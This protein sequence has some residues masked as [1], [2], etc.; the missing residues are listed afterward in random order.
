[1]MRKIV[2]NSSGHPLKNQKFFQSNEFLSDA[3]SEGKLIVRP[4]PA[5]VGNESL[6]FLKRLHGD[7]CCPIHPLY[8]PFR[9]FMVMIDASSGWSHVSML[10]TRNSAF[11]KFVSQIIR[12][13]A[14]FPD[15][16]IKKVRLDNVGEFFSQAFN[17]YC[18]SIGIDV[19]HLVCHVHTQNDMTESLIERL[20]LIA[21]PLILRTKLPISVWGHAILHVAVLVQIRPSAYNKYSLLRLTTGQEPN[22]GYLCVFGCAVYVPIALLQRKNIGPSPHKYKKSDKIIY[23]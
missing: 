9:Y 6:L 2:Q 21:R 13:K 11:A 22:V 20:Q 23:L 15:Y 18:M 3:C 8:G 5:K 4:S 16:A 12:L 7:I 17:D 19:E 14:Q 10:T 1:M